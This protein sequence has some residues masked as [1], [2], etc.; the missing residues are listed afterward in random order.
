MTCKQWWLAF[1]AFWAGMAAAQGVWGWAGDYT[2]EYA[3]ELFS[4]LFGPPPCG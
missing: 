1:F 2:Y 3:L 4:Q